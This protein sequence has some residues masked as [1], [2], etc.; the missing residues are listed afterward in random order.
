M[1]ALSDGGKNPFSFGKGCQHIETIGAC[2]AVFVQMRV[3][4][5]E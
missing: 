1:A 5:I 4:I 3:E 2:F